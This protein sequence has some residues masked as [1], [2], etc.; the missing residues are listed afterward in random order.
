MSPGAPASQ[1]AAYIGKPRTGKCG[2]PASNTALPPGWKLQYNGSTANGT[3]NYVLTLSKPGSGVFLFSRWPPPSKPEDIPSL[4]REQADRFV[5]RE[6]NGFALDSEKYQVEPFTGDHCSGAFN[7][8][9]EECGRTSH[10]Y[11]QRGRPHLEWT[12]HRQPDGL[13]T[14][15]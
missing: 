15:P 4:V 11:D 8:R 6:S 1:S 14:R 10:V 7:F 5:Q 12:I 13:G 2:R 9:G 3:D